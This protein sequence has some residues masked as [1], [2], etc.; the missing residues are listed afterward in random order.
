MEQRYKTRGIR[1]E[2]ATTIIVRTH[3]KCVGA[4]YKI[5]EDLYLIKR[6][7]KFMNSVLMDI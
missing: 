4:I 7:F 5:K 2:L 1:L 3:S 6:T